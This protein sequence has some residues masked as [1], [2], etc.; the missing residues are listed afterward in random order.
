[1]LFS[2]NSKLSTTYSLSILNYRLS[3][4][5][6]NFQSLEINLSLVF[7]W[8]DAP[9]FNEEVVIHQDFIKRLDN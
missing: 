7:L 2:P 4:T 9:I 1:M 3:T 5:I 6:E 8:R